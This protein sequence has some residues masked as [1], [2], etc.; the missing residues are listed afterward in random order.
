MCVYVCVP[1]PVCACVCLCVSL[2]VFR[3]IH[4]EVFIYVGL[5]FQGTD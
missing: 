1:V 5:E 3:S 2:S 4:H